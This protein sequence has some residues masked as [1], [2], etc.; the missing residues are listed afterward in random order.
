M[1]FSSWTKNLLTSEYCP[2]TDFFYPCRCFPSKNHDLTIS[3]CG[4]AISDTELFRAFTRLNTYLNG[5]LTSKSFHKLEISQTSVQNLYV[6]EIK[7]F[8]GLTFKK[9]SIID[10]ELENFDPFIFWS[11]FKLNRHF[12]LKGHKKLVNYN[13]RDPL[14]TLNRFRRL[15]TLTI[16]ETNFDRIA[17]NSFAKSNQMQLRK[18]ILNKNEITHIE[19]CAFFKLKRLC[20]LD[21]SNNKI[22]KIANHA[23][24]IESS[25]N[26][27]LFINLHSNNLSNTS[28][29]IGSFLQ[30]NRPLFL[31]ISDN[32][33]THLDEQIFG[34]LLLGSNNATVVASYNPFVCDCRFEWIVKNRQQLYGKLLGN[35]LC[36][37][38]RSIWNFSIDQ[39]KK[40]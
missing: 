12:V 29:S 13:R 21:L 16:T 7:L 26:T 2:P 19:S 4:K 32:L 34:P 35:P 28:L 23:F 14:H 39:L 24:A 40:C 9:I 33:L 11:S 5:S 27:R 37:D 18:L 22:R 10:N 6:N 25:S 36:H 15:E 1:I 8:K 38:G 17:K 30:I 3:C 31:I 20:V